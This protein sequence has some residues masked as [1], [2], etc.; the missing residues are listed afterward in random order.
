MHEHA[1]MQRRTMIFQLRAKSQ[2]S[3]LSGL[4]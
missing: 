3:E 2:N 1:A 4:T